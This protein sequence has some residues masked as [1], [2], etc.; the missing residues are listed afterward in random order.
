MENIPS[1]EL[2]KLT[3]QKFQTNRNKFFVIY[4]KTTCETLKHI[5]WYEFN[6]FPVLMKI[7]RDRNSKRRRQTRNQFVC[8][9]YNFSIWILCV[10]SVSFVFRCSASHAVRSLLPQ[11]LISLFGFGRH[12]E[13]MLFSCTS[14]KYFALTMASTSI[15]SRKT[16]GKL[17]DIVWWQHVLVNFIQLF[18]RRR[19]AY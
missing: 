19:S 1:L 5:E 17:C 9:F 13:A 12:N 6:G 10:F 14:C 4:H 15:T 3:S 18:S 7:H 11:E 8:R 16:E 2:F